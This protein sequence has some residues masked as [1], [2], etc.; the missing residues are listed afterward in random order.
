LLLPK[1]DLIA[2]D[3]PSW[4]SALFTAKCSHRPYPKP[5]RAGETAILLAGPEA[6][7]AEAYEQETIDALLRY[8]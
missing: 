3:A 4:S 1:E 2:H 7:P 5:W 6:L 8:D